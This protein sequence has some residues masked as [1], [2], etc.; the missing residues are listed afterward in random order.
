MS[1]RFSNYL[2]KI[3][4]SSGKRWVLVSVLNVICFKARG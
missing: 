3:S 4:K 2:G 1:L